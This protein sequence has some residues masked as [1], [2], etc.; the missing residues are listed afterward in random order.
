MSNHKFI[1]QKKL[2]YICFIYGKNRFFRFFILQFKGITLSSYSQT[3]LYPISWK[4]P[5]IFTEDLG[6]MSIQF[7]PNIRLPENIRFRPNWGSLRFQLNL[8]MNENLKIFMIKFP[9]FNNLYATFFRKKRKKVEI[10]NI[11]KQTEFFYLSIYLAYIN[12]FLVYII[13]NETV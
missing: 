6:D 3:G 12:F 8:N 10:R 5:S 4:W 11:R 2:G 13:I 7:T 1:D 9:K